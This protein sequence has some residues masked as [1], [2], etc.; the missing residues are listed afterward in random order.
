MSP[1][2]DTTQD[3]RYWGTYLFFVNLGLWFSKHLNTFIVK[4]IYIGKL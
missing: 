2:F 3:L 4:H 1:K